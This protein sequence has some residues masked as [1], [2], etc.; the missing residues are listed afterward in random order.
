MKKACFLWMTG[1]RKICPTLEVGFYDILPPQFK[2]S[3]G[4]K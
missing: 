2:S 1:S 3:L 4:I